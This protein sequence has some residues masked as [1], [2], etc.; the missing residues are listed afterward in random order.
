MLVS[1]VSSQDGFYMS[2]ILDKT[3]NW[4]LWEQR[5]CLDVRKKRKMEKTEIGN[6]LQLIFSNI[7]FLLLRFLIK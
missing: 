1:T 7:M 6:L 4:S 3:E 2:T 5:G